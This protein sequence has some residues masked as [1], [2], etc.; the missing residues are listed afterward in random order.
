MNGV[1]VGGGSIRIH[2]RSMQEHVLNNVLGIGTD[3][4]SNFLKYLGSGCPPHGG[5]AL[6]WYAAFVVAT[7]WESTGCHQ[8]IL[9]AT[10][11]AK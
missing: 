3:E 10:E 1:E 4:F 6:G 8:K 11:Q 5:I 9:W 7:P 2:Q